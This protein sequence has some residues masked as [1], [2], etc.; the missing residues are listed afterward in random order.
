MGEKG[1]KEKG[2][3]EFGQFCA[4]LFLII[5]SA[6]TNGIV[7]SSMWN[8]FLVPLGVSPIGFW[9]AV[10]ISMT[11]STTQHRDT[12][13]KDFSVVMKESFS[14]NVAKFMLL[15]LGAIVRLFI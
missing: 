13:K 1:I 6:I 11:V 7:V 3:K 15:G 5:A 12:A 2:M 4:W 8:W 14:T 10:G 9:L